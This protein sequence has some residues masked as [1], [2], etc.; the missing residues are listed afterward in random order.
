MCEAV[1]GGIDAQVGVAV[2]E[3]LRCCFIHRERAGGGDERLKTGTK[4]MGTAV[5]TGRMAV[6]VQPV[7]AGKA[8]FAF[9]LVQPSQEVKAGPR[10]SPVQPARARRGCPCGARRLCSARSSRSR[11]AARGRSCASSA[12]GSQPLAARSGAASPPGAARPCPGGRRQAGEPRGRP[13]ARSPRRWLPAGGEP[14]R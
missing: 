1:R 3:E 4:G 7:T 9:G 13:E 2:L 12:E 11:P 10:P 14:S 8:G 5:R 6:G